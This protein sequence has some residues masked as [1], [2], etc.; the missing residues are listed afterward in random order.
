MKFPYFKLPDPDKTKKFL[1]FPWIPVSINA[2]D[3]SR[4]FLMLVDSGADT[5]I[6]DRDIADFLGINIFKGKKVKTGGIG[7]NALI[8][9][10]DNI[11]INVGGKEIKIRCGFING[12]LIGGKIGGLLG[13]EGFFQNFKVCMNEKKKKI[14]LK[15]FKALG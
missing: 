9:Y 3:K 5:C 7:G 8:Y 4:T 15:E 6:F 10:F 12:N 11:F 2:N 13:R 1:I 14:E